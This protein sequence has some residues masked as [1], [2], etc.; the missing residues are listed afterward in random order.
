MLQTK[1]E[2]PRKLPEVSQNQLKVSRKQQK[3]VY[4]LVSMDSDDYESVVKSSEFL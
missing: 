2:V 4:N 3:L 1:L